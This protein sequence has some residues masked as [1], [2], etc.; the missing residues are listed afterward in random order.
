ME[1]M[2]FH[3]IVAVIYK[4][5]CLGGVFFYMVASAY[6]GHHGNTT[7]MILSVIASNSWGILLKLEL[8]K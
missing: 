5:A 3:D 8:N 7:N 1:G 6:F 4:I 2:N